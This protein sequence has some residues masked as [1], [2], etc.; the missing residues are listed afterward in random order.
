[1]AIYPNG[2]YIV[3]DLEDVVDGITEDMIEEFIGSED[4]DAF[5]GSEVTIQVGDADIIIDEVI[6][7]GEAENIE[8]EILRKFGKK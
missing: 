1:M 8:S 5:I 6:D 3:I 7:E 2:F 4:F